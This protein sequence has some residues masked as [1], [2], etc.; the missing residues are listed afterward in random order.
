VQIVPPKPLTETEVVKRRRDVVEWVTRDALLS[1]DLRAFP[2]VN[3]DIRERVDPVFCGGPKAGAFKWTDMCANKDLALQQLLESIIWQRLVVLCGAGL[4]MAPPSSLPSAC[5][6]AQACTQEYQRNGLALPATVDPANLEAIAEH[7]AAIGRLEGVFIQK[8]L[9]IQLAPFLRNSNDGHFAVADF[10]ACRATELVLSTNVDVLV[11][12][13]AEELQEPVPSVATSFAEAAQNGDHS[14]HIK[15][16]G[17]IQRDLNATLWCGSQLNHP[18]FSVTLPEFAIQLPGQ[19]I[20]KDLLVLGFWSDWSYLNHALERAVQT[21]EPNLVV[22]VD[23]APWATLV[24]KAP[25]LTR[26]AE[27]NQVQFHHVQC[28][29]SDFLLAL[30]RRYSLW[31]MDQVLR[32]GA[33]DPNQPGLL[34]LDAFG[35]LAVADLYEWRRHATG[36][37]SAMVVRQRR[38]G[39]DCEQFSRTLQNL[40]ARGSTVEGSRLR[41]GGRSARL[42]NAGGRILSSVRKEF[43]AERDPQPQDDFV[44]CAGGRDDG[45]VPADIVRSD[46]PASV[47]RPSSAARW[48]TD[49]DIAELTQGGDHALGA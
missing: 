32:L 30:R 8:L 41:V 27:G 11:E 48:I 31:F 39:V 9:R 7:F 18:P 43:N 40:L 20:D 26:W 25:T 38:P 15:L 6:L 49:A 16:H 34:S 21:S 22:V 28:S 46:A 47:I 2:N 42:V 3:A 13:A 5:A 23:P 37:S 29:A 36:R 19:L 12:R 10:L 45:G 4:S 35:H 24:A 33:D 14:P 17:C 1:T 44:V